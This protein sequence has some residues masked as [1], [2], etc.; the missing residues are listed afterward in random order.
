M[1][2]TNPVYWNWFAKLPCPAGTAT[3]GV[4]G[5][6]GTGA[7]T[8]NGVTSGASVTS[9]TATLAAVRPLTVALFVTEPFVTS[10]AV[11]V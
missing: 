2:G 5:L 3:H 9:L 10:A 4:P 6:K 1:S 8:A 11:I 7:K